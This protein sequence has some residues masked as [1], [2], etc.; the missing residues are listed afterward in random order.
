MYTAQ[1]PG[2]ID[3]VNMVWEAHL[4]PVCY[5]LISVV[6]RILA[7]TYWEVW[8]GSD[9]VTSAVSKDKAPSLH[10]STGPLFFSLIKLV[11]SV[12]C[13]ALVLK[14]KQIKSNCKQTTEVL[15][16]QMAK[17]N[18][19]FTDENKLVVWETHTHYTHRVDKLE[20]S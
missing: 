8:I 14:G 12:H 10:A 17:S 3:S 4:E 5:K 2:V 13:D 6:M 9:I 20:N 7:T 11:S 1:K 19:C 16:D 15:W 18:L